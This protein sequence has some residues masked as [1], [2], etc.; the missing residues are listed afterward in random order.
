MQIDVMGK[1]SATKFLF[2]AHP[3]AC[4]YDQA[5]SLFEALAW[6]LTWCRTYGPPDLFEV[7]A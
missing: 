3:A 5:A 4:R 2:E 1:H 6:S 7:F